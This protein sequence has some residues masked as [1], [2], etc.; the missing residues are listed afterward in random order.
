MQGE[1]GLHL[2]ELPIAVPSK[3]PSE[4]SSAIWTTLLGPSWGCIVSEYFS[5]WKGGLGSSFLFWRKDY[6]FSIM[7]ERPSHGTWITLCTISI[8][9]AAV[10]KPCA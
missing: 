7:G 2:A 1:R 3:E 5:V 10:R 9:R 8:W 4:K 6:L